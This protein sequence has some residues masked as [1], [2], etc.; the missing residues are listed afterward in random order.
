M[1]NI[2]RVPLSWAIT[3]PKLLKPIWDMFSVPQQVFVKAAYGLPLESPAEL[4]AWAILNGAC[5]YDELGYPKNVQLIPYEPHE[6][7]E[8][9]GVIGRRAGKSLL[10]CFMVLYEAT[11]GGHGAHTQDD[12]T[13]LI[14]YV[15]YDLATA[16]ENMKYIPILAKKSP[17]L[18]KEIVTATRDKIEFR[19]GCIVQPEPPTVKT[20]RGVSVPVVVMDEVGFWYKTA[21]NINPDYEVQRALTY[22]Q[23]QFSHFKQFIISTPYTEEGLLWEYAKGGTRGCHLP[24]DHEEKSRFAD[25]IVMRTSTAAMENPMIA[26][27]GR[28]QMMKIRAKD[29][30]NVFLRESLAMFTKSESNYIPGSL[31]DDCTDV[32]VH[33][34]KKEDV[35]K[36]GLAPSYVAVMDP[37]FRHDDFVFTIGH[38]DQYNQIV[39]D[40]MHV[41]T[42]NHKLGIKLDPEQ[43]MWQIG[44]WLKE[45]KIPIVYSDQYQLEAL[46]Q[47]AMRHGFSIV[48]HDFTGRSKVKIYGSLEQLLKTKKIRLLDVKEIRQQLSQLNKMH[49]ALGNIQI[50]APKGKKDDVATVIALLAHIGLEYLPEVRE[51]PKPQSLFQQLVMQHKRRQQEAEHAWDF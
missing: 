22:S 29:D 45:W 39:Q 46:N 40:M 30:P 42:P 25:A 19:N 50:G 27:H 1:A 41:W 9:V 23:S 6:Y 10:T 24:D 21:D 14:P 48:G 33:G 16:K 44:Q 8:V 26:K 17:L 31:V 15:C 43:I 49:T 7:S 4:R 28:E 13:L 47:I 34:R 51:T 36:N 18:S 5:E 11:L 3:Q 35:E 38:R 12:Q 2:E 32:G 20:G 37:A